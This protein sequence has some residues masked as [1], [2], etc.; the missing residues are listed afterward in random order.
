[1]KIFDF[2]VYSY[3]YQ[4]LTYYKNCNLDE[5]SFKSSNIEAFLILMRYHFPRNKYYK[6]INSVDSWL[7]NKFDIRTEE[8]KKN[9]R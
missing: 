9:G 2:I 5:V 6:D 3:D 8:W 7:L 1:M 4:T